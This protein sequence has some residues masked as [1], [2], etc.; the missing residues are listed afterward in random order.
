MILAKT[1]RKEKEKKIHKFG[2]KISFRNRGGWLKHSCCTTM[3]G[4]KEN[5]RSFTR[6]V[7]KTHRPAK[8]N[9]ADWVGLGNKKI[10]IVGRV[11]LGLGHKITNPPN[12]TLPT[13]FNIYLKYIIYLMIKKKISC[14]ALYIYIYI[15]IYIIF[16]N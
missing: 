4:C 15:Y 14:R 7:Q 13:I 12:P 2:I 3:C 9:P 16:N 8:P 6:V 1:T 5:W 10:F 11:G